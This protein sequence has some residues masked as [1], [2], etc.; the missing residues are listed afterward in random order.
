M[1]SGLAGTCYESEG[2]CCEE[3]AVRAFRAFFASSNPDGLSPSPRT[4]VLWHVFSHTR[5]RSIGAA[6][7]GLD[8]S[9]MLE[10]LEGAAPKRPRTDGP[11]A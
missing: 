7:D 9:G 8:D 4:G 3:E 2:G 10:V 6:K 5:F 11:S 1:L